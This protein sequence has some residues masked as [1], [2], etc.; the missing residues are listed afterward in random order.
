MQEKIIVALDY[1]DVASAMQFVDQ[2]TPADCRLKVGNILFT[3][4]GP[5]IVS[6][7]VDRGFDVFL[8]LKYHDIPNTVLGAVQAAADL[9]VWMC[10]F[11]CASG[12][13]VLEAIGRWM[14]QRQQRPLCI[15]VTVLT[16]LNDAAIAEVGLTA[17]VDQSVHALAQ[18]AY[19]C[20][21]DGVVCSAH[22]VSALKSRISPDLV[23][24]TPGIRLGGDVQDQQRVMT[25]QAA[26]QAGAD[27]LVM[28]RSI[29]QAAEPVATLR[30]IALND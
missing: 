4:A 20:G 6:E 29:T 8:D 9:G 13:P 12:R 11:H 10:N 22:E 3:Q 14:Q 1:P 17:G 28:G 16:S 25:P 21:I 27:H 18:L 23:T 19:D 5:A 15:G 2:V 7:L 26:W 24:V 30:S